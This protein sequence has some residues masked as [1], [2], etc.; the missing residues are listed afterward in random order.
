MK[1]PRV[2]GDR[3]KEFLSQG[4]RFDGRKNDQF[5]EMSIEAGVSKKAEGSARVKIGKT[6]VIVGVKMTVSEPYPDSPNKGNLM[7]T[8]ELTPL[9][10]PR[11]DLGRPGFN[12][13]EIGRVID[14]ALRESG[15]IEFEK[16]VI[17]EGEKVWTIFV[18]IYSLNDDGNLLDA[19]G[20]GAIVALKTAKLPKYDEKEEKV[21]HGEWTDK[22]VPLSDKIPVSITVHKLGDHLVVDPTREEEDISE[23]RVTVGSY[24]GIISSIQK[25]ERESIDTG[26]FHKAL[27]IIEKVRDEVFKKMEKHLK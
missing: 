23:T 21:L 10:S 16:L 13:I 18:D 17:K 24:N 25:G 12:S 14:R 15:F 4:K 11:I 26:E 8:A 1:T 5:R 9:S 22:G 7:T 19:A 3:I 27:D 6:D 20:I 2:T